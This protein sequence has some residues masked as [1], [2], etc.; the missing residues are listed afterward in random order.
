MSVAT[1]VAGERSARAEGT[2]L[3]ASARKSGSRFSEKP[4]RNKELIIGPDIDIW[5]G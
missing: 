4:M 2:H 5:S 3:A 1:Y